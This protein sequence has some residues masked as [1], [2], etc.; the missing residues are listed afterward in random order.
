M[1]RSALL[2]DGEYFT[3]RN[4]SIKNIESIASMKKILANL[5]LVIGLTSY[6]T[7]STLFTVK[8]LL[9]KSFVPSIVS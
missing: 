9:Y 7:K 5:G 3:K 4:E 2:K 8:Y 1:T 6:D